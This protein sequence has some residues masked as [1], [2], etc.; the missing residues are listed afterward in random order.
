MAHVL[1]AS[2][3]LGEGQGADFDFHLRRLQFTQVTL[4]NPQSHTHPV[5]VG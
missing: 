4:K 5:R 3:L 2:S 1:E